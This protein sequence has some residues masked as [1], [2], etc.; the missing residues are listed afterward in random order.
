MQK[1]ASDGKWDPNV[2][3]TAYE[4]ILDGDGDWSE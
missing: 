3:S 4:K 2:R 1:W